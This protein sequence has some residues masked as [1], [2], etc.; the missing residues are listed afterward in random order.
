MAENDYSL[1]LIDDDNQTDPNG[2]EVSSSR[3]DDKPLR[4]RHGARNQHKIKF[5]LRW[6]MATF[7]SQLA[8]ASSVRAQEQDEDNGDETA[9]VNNDE[10]TVDVFFDH[11]LVLDVA[12]GKGE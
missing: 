10:K 11:P 4:K 7:P 1:P 3:E 8:A 9:P 6:L 2:T 12:G 5:F